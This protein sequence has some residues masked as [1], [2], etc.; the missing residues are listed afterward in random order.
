MKKYENMDNFDERKHIIEVTLQIWESKWTFTQEIWWNTF[1][2]SVLNFFSDFSDFWEWDEKYFLNNSCNLEFN[3][4][5]EW[6]L[7]FKCYLK[8]ED[9]DICE[10]EDIIYELSKLVVKLE[11]IDCKIV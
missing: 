5:S 1:W 7:W 3:E 9:W 4:D 6:E 11:I 8:D 10:Y 2:A